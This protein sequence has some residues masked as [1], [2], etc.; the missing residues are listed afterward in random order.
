LSRK[1]IGCPDL[2]I[3]L[4]A[5]NFAAIA[6]RRRICMKNILNFKIDYEDIQK[7]VVLSEGGRGSPSP[8]HPIVK[9]AATFEA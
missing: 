8:I 1:H 6:Q 5:A 7:P 2:Q 4:N 9:A 3:T